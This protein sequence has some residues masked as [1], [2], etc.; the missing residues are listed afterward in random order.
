MGWLDNRQHDAFDWYEWRD[1]TRSR[2]GLAGAI[3]HG[4]SVEAGSRE[5]SAQFAFRSGPDRLWSGAFAR[6]E[7]EVPGGGLRANLH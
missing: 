4:S 3:A 6:G 5:K 2:R 7:G 1:F